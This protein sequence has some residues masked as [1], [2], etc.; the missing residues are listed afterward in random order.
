MKKRDVFIM[1]S[2]VPQA[3]AV[4]TEGWRSPVNTPL[5]CLGINPLSCSAQK[6]YQ[7]FR[8]NWSYI[9]HFQMYI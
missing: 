8:S 7:Y 2:A 9:C 6:N 5:L 4:L 3:K 1:F